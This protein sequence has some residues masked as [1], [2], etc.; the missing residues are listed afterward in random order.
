LIGVPS[1]VMATTLIFDV[2]DAK[3]GRRDL[4]PNRGEHPKAE[5]CRDVPQHV[6]KLD[7]QGR[8]RQL[9]P[10]D[11][12][13]LPLLVVLPA[14]DRVVSPP[15]DL[16][17]DDLAVRVAVGPGIDHAV[18]RQYSRVLSQRGGSCRRVTPPVLGAKKMIT[19]E[20]PARRVGRPHP[21]PPAR[22]GCA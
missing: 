5:R 22:A 19:G 15:R 10:F 13:E 6:G 17:L 7:L 9:P 2:G 21:A 14:V 11:A 3:A 1:L 18:A 8:M 16:D 20:A 4:N 12:R